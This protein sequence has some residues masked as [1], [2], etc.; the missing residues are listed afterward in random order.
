MRFQQGELAITVKDR[1]IGVPK[2]DRKYLFE[3]FHR[4]SNTDNIE[5]T[6][7][8]LSIVKRCVEVMDGKI[9]FTSDLDTGSSFYVYVP[10]YEPNT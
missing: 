5:G 8:G 7:L 1:G 3:L 6:G 9:D 10:T 2:K 4:A